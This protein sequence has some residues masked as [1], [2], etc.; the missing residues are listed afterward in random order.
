MRSHDLDEIATNDPIM[1]T[2]TH[3]HTR[4]ERGIIQG[5]KRS[6]RCRITHYWTS[7][8]ACALA[9]EVGDITVAPTHAQRWKWMCGALFWP[10]SSKLSGIL[11]RPPGGRASGLG[12]LSATKEKKKKGKLKQGEL[13][14]L[15]LVE[16]NKR[17]KHGREHDSDCCWSLAGCRKCVDPP[18]VGSHESTRAEQAAAQASEKQFPSTT[19]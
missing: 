7:H 14:N 8:T 18:L 10:R 9:K 6:A 12:V 15:E 17:G 5:K 3:T 1:H 4:M 2:H 19:P 11:D 13:L 16:R